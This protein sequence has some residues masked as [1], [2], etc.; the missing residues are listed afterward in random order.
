M[1]CWFDGFDR[2]E[3][4]DRFSNPSNPVN[5]SN[6]SNLSNPSNRLVLAVLFVIAAASGVHAADPVTYSKDVAPILFS[7]C[8]VCHHPGGSAPFSVLSY[9]A[10]RQHASQIVAVTANGY[11]PPWKADASVGGGFVGQSRLTADE[12]ALLA[13]WVSE[14][15]REG[16]PRD[17]PAVPQF[18]AG[19]QLGRP[20]LVLTLPSYTVPAGGTDVF[21]IFVLPIPVDRQRFVRGVEFN[22]GNPAIVHHANIRIDRTP[23]S[24]RFDAA[25]PT[26]GYEGLIAHSATYPDGH[27]L[28]WTPG[29]VA[30][31]LPRGLAWR[32]DPGTDLVV[33][34]HMQP[35]GRAEPVAPS[36]AL[37]FGTDPPERVPSMLR[38]GRQ[39]IDIPAGEPAYTIADSFVLPVDVSVQA[40]Q[41]HAHY[42][43]REVTGTATLPD[44]QTR[45]L[46]HIADWDF[47]WQHVYRYVEPVALPK[48][49]TV[50]MRYTYDNS[51]GNPRN[52][53]QPPRR[54]YW[55][56][57][58]ADEMGD[59]WIQVLTPTDRDLELLDSRFSVKVMAEDTIGYER[60]IQSEPESAA[61][62]DDVAGLYLKLNRPADAVRHF[63]ISAGLQP[64][65]AA[66]HFNLATALTL[67]GSLLAAVKEYERAL[68][69]NPAYAAAHNNLGGAL[70]RLNRVDEALPHLLEALRLEPGNA[71]AHYNAG[72]AERTRGRF[73]DA[74]AHFRRALQ[75]NDN[76]PAALSDLAWLL[77]VSP[78]EALRD[79]GGAVKYAEQAAALSG[80]QDP[81]VLDVLAAAY[82]AAG[83]YMR[84]VSEADAALALKPANAD[85]IAVRRA[86]Y[87]QGRPF[88][89]SA[90]R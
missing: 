73:A 32:L 25:D 33:E 44:G 22:P 40:V 53:V 34:V 1:T 83:Q 10:V 5:H 20:D 23:A 80:R 8:A 21:R 18:S 6:P 74:I 51:A 4:F 89:L 82:A 11:M 88:R 41:P 26:P 37:Y 47:R 59:L 3:R 49:T 16:S 7:K 90:Q 60:W 46:I 38:L 79:P 29:Q 63:A 48:G 28:G 87:A 57:R 43:A 45:T 61:L 72:V 67:A 54:V 36:V 31:L 39:G 77:A 2:F 66:A 85:A 64:T 56:Q 86:L 78:E 68:E 42:R 55:G 76:W 69:L 58:S 13:R 14:G 75:P 27:F 65:V 12:R 30:P 24:R 17:L 84:A 81:V 19:W 50:S 71:L 52:P 15:S 9:A 70:N 35:S 62:H